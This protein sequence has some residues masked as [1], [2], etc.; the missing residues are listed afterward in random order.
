M[1]LTRALL[2][3]VVAGARSAL[4]FALLARRGVEGHGLAARALRHRW[5]RPV[6]TLAAG[7]EL[8]GDKLPMT[9]S[10]LDP[11]ALGGRAVIGAVAGAL[12]GGERDGSAVGGAVLGAAGAVLGA[13]ALFHARRVVSGHTPLPDRVVGGLED[14][15]VLAVGR[16]ATMR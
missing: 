12:L 10:R 14:A 3:G 9:P 8:V 1:D 2:I 4:P 15:L 16:R 7:G 13:Y 5:A 6:T 11:G